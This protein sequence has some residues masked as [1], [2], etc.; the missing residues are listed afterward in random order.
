MSFISSIEAVRKA[1]AIYSFASNFIFA[2]EDVVVQIGSNELNAAKR[3]LSDMRSSNNPQRELNMAITQ[4]RSALEHFDSKRYT[5]GGLLDDW[6]AMEKSFQTALFIAVCYS[7]IGESILSEKFRNMSC[8]YFAEWLDHY[9]RPQGKRWAQELRYDMV[10]DKV[11]EMGLSWPYSYP[12]SSWNPFSSEDSR[13]FHEAYER[14]KEA[15]KKQYHEWTY[16]L[17]MS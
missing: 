3:S 9:N 8:D 4:L 10:K 12:E 2:A 5:L 6:G 17:T 14:H 1:Y 15:V 13:K 7:F 16:M 11:N